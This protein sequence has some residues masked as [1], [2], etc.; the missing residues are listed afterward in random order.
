VLAPVFFIFNEAGPEFHQWIKVTIKRFDPLALQRGQHLERDQR[1]IGVSDVFSD[2]H[3]R[4]KLTTCY[5]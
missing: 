5:H 4:A 2:L 3:K 1:V